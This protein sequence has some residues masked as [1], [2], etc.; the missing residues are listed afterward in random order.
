[1][2]DRDGEGDAD[3]GVAGDASDGADDADDADQESQWRFSLDDLE[4][5]ESE[6]EAAAEAERRRQEPIEAGDPSL[7]NALFV[8]LGV[9]LTLFVVSRLFVA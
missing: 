7:E 8:L 6:A 5:R 9:V 2:S 4:E 3:G 1:M